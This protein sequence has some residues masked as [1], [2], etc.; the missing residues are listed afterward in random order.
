MILFFFLPCSVLKNL[1]VKTGQFGSLVFG[2]GGGYGILGSGGAREEG[3]KGAGR[4]R[5]GYSVQLFT[6]FIIFTIFTIFYNI[7]N[8]LRH[9]RSAERDN[10]CTTSKSLEMKV[11]SIKLYL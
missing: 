7:Y 9:V 10:K 8:M 2:L 5:E 1:V 4:G 11:S 6:I 3:R